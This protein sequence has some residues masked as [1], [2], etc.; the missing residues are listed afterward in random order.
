MVWSP[1]E[2]H[3][4]FG[5]RDNNLGF[6][7]IEPQLV[8]LG[9]VSDDV[10]G[11]LQATGAVREQVGVISNTDSSGI[12]GSKVKAKVGAVER[13]E[14][15]IYVSFEVPTCP[16]MALPVSLVLCHLPAELV[17]QLDVAL[18]VLVGVLAIA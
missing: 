2:G 15:G 14:A 4:M 18:S 7:S 16:D 5:A 17:L 11:T 6:T 9:I 12:D 1:L 13:E 8:S 3:V 10:Q